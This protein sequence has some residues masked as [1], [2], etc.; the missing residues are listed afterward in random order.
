VELTV[1]PSTPA[2]AVRNG[3]VPPVAVDH[4]RDLLWVGRASADGRESDYARSAGAWAG[5]SALALL[6]RHN[7]KVGRR[8]FLKRT[9]LCAGA[10]ALA[11]AAGLTTVARIHAPDQARAFDRAMDRLDELDQLDGLD[12]LDGVGRRSDPLHA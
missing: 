11:P 7:A 5:A 3:A 2:P 9:L 6:A 4:A 8:R 12:R 1:R 10:L